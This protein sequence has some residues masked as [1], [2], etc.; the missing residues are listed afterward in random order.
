MRNTKIANFKVKPIFIKVNVPYR[1][2]TEFKE[3]ENRFA[4]TFI[5]FLIYTFEIGG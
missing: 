3:T 5:V 1:Q 2:I 4:I